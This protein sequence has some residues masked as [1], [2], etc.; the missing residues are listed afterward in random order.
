V[1]SPLA[2]LAQN[3]PAG[4]QHLSNLSWH[5]PSPVGGSGTIKGYN[6]YRSTSGANFTKIN[7]ALIPV[8]QTG[9]CLDNGT[10]SNCGVY[11][12]LTV[13]AGAA[14]AYCGSTVDSNNDESACSI[15]VSTTIPTNPNPQTGLAAVSQ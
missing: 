5:A 4:T 8:T 9:T 1:W 7:S 12:D 3:P 6:L 10:L 2:L 14:Y 15:Q 13:A 11:T